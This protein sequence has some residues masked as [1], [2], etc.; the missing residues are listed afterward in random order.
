MTSLATPA[1]DGWNQRSE[2]GLSDTSPN[3]FIVPN[4]S[5]HWTFGAGTSVV[6]PVGDGV[7]DCD[8]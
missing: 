1:V 6:I 2:T 4:L 8:K 7:T 5:L 3:L